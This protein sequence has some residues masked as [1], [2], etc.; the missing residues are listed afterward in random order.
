[1]NSENTE[2]RDLGE[3]TK[4]IS[5]LKEQVKSK[6]LFPKKSTKSKNK[7]DK[8]LLLFQNDIN[9]KKP[10]YFGKTRSLFF[11]GETPIFILGESRNLIFYHLKYLL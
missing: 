6:E 4:E 3:A 8:S 9:N 10:K 2:I 11:I 7:D 1:M 5:T